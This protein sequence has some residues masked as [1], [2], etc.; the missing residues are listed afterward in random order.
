MFHIGA[1]IL[2]YLGAPAL[3]ELFFIGVGSAL[4][5]AVGA[6]SSAM[7]K[8][9]SANGAIYGAFSGAFNGAF[10]VTF[11][12][13]LPSTCAGR[14]AYVAID[15]FGS[16]AIG[17]CGLL[18]TDSRSSFVETLEIAVVCHGLC[19]A[20]AVGL[21]CC[22]FAAPALRPAVQPVAPVGAAPQMAVPEIG[23]GPLMLE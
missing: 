7:L 3:P 22:A 10:V 11:S 5:A 14:T 9:A 23:A 8:K 12:P 15:F 13:L 17:Y 6:A 4:R 1:N 19:T 2:N 20:I 21:S 18:V 16:L